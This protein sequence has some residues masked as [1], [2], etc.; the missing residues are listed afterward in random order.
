[1]Y[2]IS[3]WIDNHPGGYL[4]LVNVAGRDAT[5]N[6]AAYHPVF[7]WEKKLPY[8]LIG[9][10]PE[11]EAKATPFQRAY[12]SVQQQLLEAGLH[13]TRYSYYAKLF[14]WLAVLFSVVLFLSVKCQVRVCMFFPLRFLPFVFVFWFFPLNLDLCLCACAYACVPVCL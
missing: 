10:L 2:D 6:F 5:D 3:K 8:F 4:P 14:T 7:V 13:Q 11:A 9:E 1:M 12:R